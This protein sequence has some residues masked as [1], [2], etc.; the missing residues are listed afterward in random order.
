MSTP[1]LEAHPVDGVDD[2]VNDVRRRTA[3]IVN[4]LVLPNERDL[5]DGRPSA[6]RHEITQRVKAEGL[7]APHLPT[8]YGGMGLD[9]VGHALMN[10]VLAYS[11]A[12][13]PLFGVVAPNAANEELL[14][15]LGTDDQK[16]RWLLPLV[17]GSLQSAFSMTEPDRPGSD[18]RAIGTTARRDGDEWVVNGRKWFTSNGGRA[19]FFV[20]MCRVVLDGGEPSPDMVQLIVPGA[21]DGVTRVRSI[22]VWG[23]PTSEHWEIRYDDVRVPFDS[24]V[25]G[26]DGGHSAAQLRL[27]A[28]RVYHCMT[29]IGQMWRAF[30]LM[31]ER[32]STRRVH[33]GLLADMQFTQGAIADSYLDIQSSRLMTLDAAR[34]VDLGDGLA[35]VDVSAIKVFVAEAWHRVADRAIQVWG[36]AGITDEL[37]LGLMYLGAR[38]LRIADGPDEVH[39]ILIAKQVLRRRA[40]G[41]GWPFGR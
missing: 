34:K 4:E 36:A 20:V 1:A 16:A 32:A 17:E 18:P 28:G 40:E 10:E 24:V 12:A 22:G 41:H 30:D 29:A 2:A 9:V 21:A 3:S 11:L 7:W 33:G 15:R 37:P 27:G 13:A 5:I 31:V 23:Q 14:A 6:L 26:P 35:R 19:D 8:D 38:M 39:R 25:G